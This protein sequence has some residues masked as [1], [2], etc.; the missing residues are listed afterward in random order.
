MNVLEKLDIEVQ[1][2]VESAARRYPRRGALARLATL[3]F[4][5]AAGGAAGLG[6]GLPGY[7]THSCGFPNNTNCGSIWSTCPSSGG[8]PG[9]CG[10]CSNGACAGCIHSSGSGSWSYYQWITEPGSCGTCG[11]VICSDCICPNGAGCSGACG[12]MS[13][14][15]CTGCCS[16]RAIAAEIKK[17][18][19][20]QEQ[21][22]AAQ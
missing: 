14:C 19:Q 20:A 4:A 12:C 8:C 7:A 6:R 10:A 1:S 9:G 11:F 13:S 2:A 17:L 3:G 18:R 5:F 22:A 21:Q 15:Q 16:A